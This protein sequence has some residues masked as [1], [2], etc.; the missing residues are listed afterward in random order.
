VRL[1]I[2]VIPLLLLAFVAAASP[3]D[4]LVTI[5]TEQPPPQKQ[6]ISTHVETKSAVVIDGVPAFRWYRGCTPTAVGM[7][8]AHWDIQG[9]DVLPGVDYAMFQSEAMNEAIAS[10]EHWQ[11]YALPLDSWGPL[12]ADRSEEPEGDEHGDNSIADC[13]DTSHSTVLLRYG[14]TWTSRIPGCLERYANTETL[15]GNMP[16][17][18]DDCW[19]FFVGEIDAGRPVVMTV[20]TPGGLHSVAGV[21]YDEEYYGVLDTWGSEVVWYPYSDCGS[22]SW[23]V[24]DV[25]GLEIKSDSPVMPVEPHRIYLPIIFD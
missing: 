6:K 18:R 15:T 9:Y 16:R 11:D 23:C 3:P 14:W 1:S 10:P 25:F 21:G 13:L 12:R 20:V 17:C 7:V 22:A 5:T 4:D 19:A 24:V 2:L 8:L